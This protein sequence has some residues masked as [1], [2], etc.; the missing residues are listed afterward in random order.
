VRFF[1][2]TSVLLPCFFDNHV[3]HEAS[4]RV[5][6]GVEKHE[7]CC[8]AHSLA[9]FYANATGYP[10]R[11]RLSGP[12]ALLLVDEIRE[13]LE[14]VA[15]TSAEYYS[16]IRDAAAAGIAG[17]TI[18]DALLCRCA[19]K[20]AAEVVYTWDVRHFQQFSEDIRKRVR[21]P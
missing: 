1:F 3:H 4:L 20:A 5:F 16:A 6:L 7:G 12:E 10:G 19:E 8:G 14:I 17:G 9:E 18:Y 13:R 2:D 11:S 15:L 21:T